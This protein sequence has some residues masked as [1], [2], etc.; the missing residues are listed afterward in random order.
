MSL[1]YSAGVDES[2]IQ[3]NGGRVLTYT[4]TLTLA[5]YN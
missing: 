5:N 3:C 4:L 1:V 2:G